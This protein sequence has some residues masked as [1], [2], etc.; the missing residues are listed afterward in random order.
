M[1]PEGDSPEIKRKSSK[2][3]R[4]REACTECRRHKIRCNPRPDD[5]NHLYPCSRCE[6]MSLTCEFQKHN[7]GRKRKHPMPL[8]NGGLI[9]QGSNGEGS[10]RGEYISTRD[11]VPPQS[12]PHSFGDPRF[13]FIS[14]E[15]AELIGPKK[16]SGWHESDHETYHRHGH[17]MSLRHMLGEEPDD[18]GSVDEEVSRDEL[19]DEE[20]DGESSRKRSRVAV[21]KGSDLVD[22][23][24]RAGFVTEEEGRALFHLYLTHMNTSLPM[25]DPSFHTHNY[26]RE[27]SP[28]LY[29]AILCIMSRYLSSVSPSG[30]TVSPESAQSVHQQILIL[31][32]DHLTWSFAEAVADINTVRAMVILSLHKEPD[33]D[34]AGY[35]VSRAIL[36]GKELNLGRIPSKSES[37][38]MTDK[39]L[40][41]LRS[42]QRV[43]LCLFFVNS[44]FNMQFRQPMLILQSDPLVAT[45]HHWLKR[46]RPETLLR[47]SQLVCSTE[48]RRKYLHYRDL[49]V[50]SGPDE[51]TYRSALSLSLLTRT[52]NQDWDVT[53]EAWIR[54]IIDVGGTSSHV[55]KP[56]IWTSALRL[57]LNLLIVNQTLRLPPEDQLDF[58]APR[59]IPAFHHCLNAATTVLVRFEGLDRQ[60][61]TFAS[62]TFLHFALYA[63]TLLSTLCRGQHPYK[64]ETVEIEHC[65]RLIRKTADALEGASAYPHD[66]P[67]L[68]AYYL[69]RLGQYLPRPP[70]Q[71]LGSA[72]SFT[73]GSDMLKPANGQTA[74]D[75][76]LQN[77]S[78]GT[79]SLNTALTNALGNELDFL[80]ADFPWMEGS[81]IEW[82]NEGEAGQEQP[83][84]MHMP[85]PQAAG[86][87]YGR[88]QFGAMPGNGGF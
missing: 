13:P 41:C 40:Q 37:D 83:Q 88:G 53:S 11:R 5:P 35:Y 60:Q 32:R 22:D 43:W 69:R 80:M 10:S 18:D 68:H 31:A 47:D 3:E 39:E 29:T 57:N 58:G 45:A 74:I 52:M 14:T 82:L 30:Q 84:Q 67:A 12:L 87:S 71:N 66:S 56:R 59:S 76:I 23:P 7:R 86:L 28:F 9:D 65:R 2:V 85:H 1:Q 61:L 21:Q 38:R 20:V 78:S 8:L 19:L 50:G 75:P 17:Q 64:F 24:I 81:G 26:V 51:P 36:M 49:L 33:D 4:G 25:L 70:P 15:P 62:D 27:S 72:S 73:S 79:T 63:A 42:R 44:I 46:S 55:N 77:M 16:Q 6:R 54:D 48:L 34:K